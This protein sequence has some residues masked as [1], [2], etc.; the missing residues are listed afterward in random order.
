MI[1]KK[2]TRGHL[3]EAAKIID[4]EGVPKRRES[5]KYDVLVKGKRYPPKY[6]IAVASR[7]AIEKM[8]PAQSYNGG[9]ESNSFLRSRGFSITNKS[10][11]IIKHP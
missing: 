9:L 7:L 10:G 6:L 5:T 11:K 8:I 1:P 2:I 4:R 3:L